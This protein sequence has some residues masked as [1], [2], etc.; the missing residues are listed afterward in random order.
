MSFF[1]VASASVKTE[2]GSSDTLSYSAVDHEVHS[3]AEPLTAETA[4]KIAAL[5]VV[6]QQMASGMFA[7][8]AVHVISGIRIAKKSFK[9]AKGT[10]PDYTVELSGSGPPVPGPVA[11]ELGASVAHHREN[12]V[13]DS[14][15]TAPGMGLR[16]GCISSDISGQ[17][18]RRSCFRAR[19]RS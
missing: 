8:H 1:A 18:W 3:F 10:G 17:A 12:T 19:G 14:Y 11:L 2:L 4:M 16:T 7:K 15:E 6:Q 9:V 13:T 5:P